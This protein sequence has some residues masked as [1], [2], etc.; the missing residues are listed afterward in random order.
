M[1]NLLKAIWGA[2]A[3][4]SALTSAPA[5]MASDWSYL[6]GAS[7]YEPGYSSRYRP[8]YGGYYDPYYSGYNS[9]NSYGYGYGYRDY[10][11]YAYPRAYYAY[12]D[13]YYGYGGGY[14][15]YRRASYGYGGYGYGGG[16]YGYASAYAQ[17]YYYSTYGD[18]YDTP[19]TRLV[20]VYDDAGGWVWGRRYYC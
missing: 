2:A 7:Y 11:S 5:A 9:Y 1:R 19:C 20:R 16:Y 15:G 6:E 4:C 8:Y 17:P 14:Y 12:N 10:N 13:G 3:L 18:G